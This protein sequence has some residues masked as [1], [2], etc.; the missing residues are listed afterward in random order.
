MDDVVAV[1]SAASFVGRAAELEHL[2]ELIL[3]AA[4]GEAAAVLLSGDAGVGKTSLIAEA[5]RRAA[6]DGLLVLLGRCV[7]LG[8]GALPYLPFAEALSQLV[9]AGESQP[10]ESA[11]TGGAVGDSP[12]ARAAAIVR[13]VARERPGLG[14]IAGAG[15][16][17]PAERSPG[18]TGLD[19]LALF[20]AVAHVLGRIGDEVSPLLLIIED[21]H[22]ADAST[23]DLVRFLLARLGSDRLLVIA[24]YRGDDLHRRHPLR[25]LVGELLRLPQVERMELLPFADTELSAFLNAVHGDRLTDDVL[26]RITV[27]S[28]GNPY[29]AEELLAAGTDD[30]LPAGLADVLLDRLEHVGEPA[31]Q[32]VRMASVLGT[33]RIE[34]DLLRAVFCAGAP[35]TAD[36]LDGPVLVED[37]LREAIAHQLL[38]PDGPDR[39]AFRHALL[40]EAVYADL[41]PGERVRFHA[42]AAHR[43]AALAETD[44]RLGDRQAAELARHSLAAH[45]IPIAL[46]ASLRAAA[47]ARRRSAPAEALAH[48]EQAL[49]LWD[50][51]EAQRRPAGVDLVR[52]GVAAAAVASDAGRRYRAL[53]LAEAALQQALAE[54]PPAEVAH[55]RAAVALHT[56]G[57]DRMVEAREQARRVV[58]ELADPS[59]SAAR[60]LA[61]SIEARVDVSLS[62][63]EAA[64][65]LIPQAL[66]E[67]EALGLLG[68]Q[69]ELLTSL[70][71]AHGMVGRPD[72]ARQW[73]AARAAAERAGD[74]AV[75]I[76]VLYNTAI[77]RFDGGDPAGGAEVLEEA[78]RI[79][80]AAGLASSLYG[81]QC[82]SL[83]ITVRWQLGDAEG[84]LA[85]VRPAGQF[86]AGLARQL[87]LFELPVWAA[88]DPERVLS[89]GDWLVASDASWD[90]Q[91]LQTARAEAL[92]WLGRGQESAEAAREAIGFLDASAEPYQ[93]G[94]IAIG[95]TA[96]SA[97]A[98]VAALARERGDAVAVAQAAET[99][100]WFIDDARD[101]GRYGRP[102]AFTMGP[103]GVAWLVRL[104]VEVAR[105]GA[106][107]DESGWARV[108]GAFDGVSVYERARAR[109]RRAELLVRAGDRER[110][111]I[112]AV[113]ARQ[114]AVQLGAGPLISALDDLARRARFEVTKPIDSGLLTPREREVMSLVA[115]GLT[116]RVIGERLFI[117]EKTA[118][119]HVSNV[120]A[121][122]GASGRAEAVAIIERRRLIG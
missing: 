71:T 48:Y 57:A 110:A 34:D 5:A 2:R 70:A 41:L 85:V 79:A 101:R 68:L 81:A 109:W 76:R 1:R 26:R 92:G 93:L 45:D 28:A 121:K 65:H 49:Q 87:R 25:P 119:V 15:G 59:P 96:V 9:R 4:A 42:T 24:S 67:A 36:G 46:A 21:L 22:W 88:R 112:E 72:A 90:N 40:Q 73:A 120:L 50:A 91:I 31:R 51:V 13:Q 98:D 102:R 63:P 12:V 107:D 30:R 14:R 55:A 39:Y 114:A 19:R 118:S 32:V 20:E 37:A 54:G 17:A 80:D 52:I 77:D 64:L 23:R 75:M 99:A 105:L 113:G 6:D 117:S 8:T 111:R 16:Q 116:N 33:A 103:E 74:L 44:E 78:I 62:E 18:D 95:T 100:R 83:L 7:D 84:A 61:R 43:L 56:Y 66:A 69:A 82:R 47:E 89:S 38:V 104:D 29:Y 35:A 97:L 106:E 27:R 115:A 108:A 86:S 58:S 10:A 53:H 94:G 11:P 60:V 3:A 122:L